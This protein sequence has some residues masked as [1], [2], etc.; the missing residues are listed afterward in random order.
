MATSKQYFDAAKQL[1]AMADAQANE[2]VAEAMRK[3]ASELTIKGA[4]QMQWEIAQAKA[5]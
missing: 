2:I 4:E 5:A 1:M 3:A